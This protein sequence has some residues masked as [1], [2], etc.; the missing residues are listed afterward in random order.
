MVYRDGFP[1]SSPGPKKSVQRL[2]D[3]VA[4]ILVPGNIGTWEGVCDTL[5]R[6]VRG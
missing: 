1:G 2:K 4:A 5:N 3:K 6:L